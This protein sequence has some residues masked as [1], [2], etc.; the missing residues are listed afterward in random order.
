MRSFWGFYNNGT[1]KVGCNGG[2]VYVYNQDNIELAKFKDIKY[3]YSG[4]FVPERNVFAV[5]STEGKLAIYDLNKMSLIK[6]IRI[7]SIGT[8]DE[9]FAFSADGR[10]F[11]NIEKPQNSCNTQLT[12]YKTDDFSVVKKLFENCD[13]MVLEALEIVDDNCYVLGFM[14]NNEDVFDYGFAGVFD[15]TDITEIKKL[16]NDEYKYL[17]AYKE[18]EI[19]GFTDKCLE[20]L[21]IK[22]YSERPKASI[23]E[24]I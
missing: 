22:H 2:T 3:A 18:W 20:W 15:G 9:G 23:K 12:V 21:S 11:Y 24:Y 16:P 6:I 5:K 8:Q 1:Y 13:D 19:H 10:Y 4:A 7:T 17:V 14:R